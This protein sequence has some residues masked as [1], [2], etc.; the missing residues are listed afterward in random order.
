MDDDYTGEPINVC[1]ICGCEVIGYID[2]P[3]KEFVC[4]DCK[5]K[6]VEIFE[7]KEGNWNQIV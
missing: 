7:V 5:S 4:E 1:S 3:T 6:K 2:D